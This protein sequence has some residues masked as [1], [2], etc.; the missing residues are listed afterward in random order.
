M[1]SDAAAV[2][3]DSGKT[4]SLKEEI[5]AN[6]KAIKFYSMGVDVRLFLRKR[7]AEGRKGAK[8]A[9]SQVAIF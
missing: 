3:G 9:S 4:M 1:G 7:F 6:Q 5:D 8:D 2:E